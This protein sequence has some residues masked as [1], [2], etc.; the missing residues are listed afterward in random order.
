[1]I[2][3]TQYFKP[4]TRIPG[5]A[6][7]IPGA[8]LYARVFPSCWSLFSSTHELLAKESVVMQGPLKRFVVFQ[9][10]HRG[11]LAITSECYKYYL[12]PSGEYTTSLK[13]KLPSASLAVPL[14]S[15]GVHKHAD[16]QKI[17]QRQDL[18]EMLP[19][20]LRLAAMVPKEKHEDPLP[21]YG[22]GRLLARAHQKIREKKITE[23][24]PT[25]LS[26]VL[27]GFS[28]C[29]LPRLYDTEWQGILPDITPNH[30]LEVP[31]SLLAHSFVM[32]QEIFI[33]Y[34]GKFIQILP[35]LPPEFPCGRLVGVHLPN[36]GTL[37]MIWTKKTIRQ[38]SLEA[39]HTT[40]LF[41]QFC[42][43]LRTARLRQWTRRRFS[44][45]KQIALGENVEIKAGTTYLWDCF[46]K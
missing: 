29:F 45:F 6:L 33:S 28:E 44:G 27:S 9:D 36:I 20:W 40:P 12:L 21:T 7:P 23:I 10:L 37:S 11:G 3:L 38:V 13:G 32:L 2:S 17:R 30:E 19:L 31:F 4:Y 25:L 5:K 42:S 34:Q 26:L 41:L 15:L 1:M 14:L 18:K 22:T 24:V 8:T 39:Y 46:C 16:W 43:S 35:A